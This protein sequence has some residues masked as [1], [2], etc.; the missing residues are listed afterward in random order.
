MDRKYIQPIPTFTPDTFLP[1]TWSAKAACIEHI[2]LFD[3]VAE[4]G[5]DGPMRREAR[6]ICASCPVQLECLALAVDW[7]TAGGGGR[8][9]MWGGLTAGERKILEG[10]KRR[11]A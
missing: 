11:S 3:R 1:P 2:E 9:G 7:E 6:A 4:S 8:Y 5:V 10:T